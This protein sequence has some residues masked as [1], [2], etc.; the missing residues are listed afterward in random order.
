MAICRKSESP[1]YLLYKYGCYLLFLT[2]FTYLPGWVGSAQRNDP[3]NNG[4]SQQE[5]VFVPIR[6]SGVPNNP[7]ALE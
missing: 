4:A 5:K 7:L 6:T 3:V 2:L 1:L